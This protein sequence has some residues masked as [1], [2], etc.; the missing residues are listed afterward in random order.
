M[1]AVVLTAGSVVRLA[2]WSVTANV[3]VVVGEW[4][5]RN[6]RKCSTPQDKERIGSTNECRWLG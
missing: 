1:M 3:G 2:V 5:E 4:C 6:D